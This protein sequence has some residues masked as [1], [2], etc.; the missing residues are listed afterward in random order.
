MHQFRVGKHY[1]LSHAATQVPLSK[2]FIKDCHAEEATTLSFF[3]LMLLCLY[4]QLPR[5][6]L[7]FILLNAGI[8]LLLVEGDTRLGWT[9]KVHAPHL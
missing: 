3:R 8:I 2:P 1:S 5:T 7:S 9:N 4:A 6:H